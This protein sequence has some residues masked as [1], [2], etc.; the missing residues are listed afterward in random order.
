MAQE[1][2]QLSEGICRVA[3]QAVVVRER[4]GETSVSRSC[5]SLAAHVTQND[6]R[7]MVMLMD[8]EDD[9][10]HEIPTHSLR[11]AGNARQGEIA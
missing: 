2:E 10:A 11:D 9:V 8:G 6:Q 5:C 4:S 7:P 1:A 3:A